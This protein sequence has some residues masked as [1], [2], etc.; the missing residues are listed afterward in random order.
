[1]THGNPDEV[2][3]IPLERGATMVLWC[4]LPAQRLPL[5]VGWYFMMLRNGVP[6]AYGGGGLFAERAEHGMNVLEAFR[7]SGD[8]AWIFAQISRAAHALCPTPW[9]VTRKFQVGGDGN[10]EGL[11]SGA[12]WFYD[13][14]GFRST[15]AGVRRLADWERRRIAR[16]T[17][18]RS[19]R[20]VLR[21]L[22]SAD[23][24]LSLEGQPPA[25]YREY[26]LDAVGLAVAR[27]TSLRFGG[28]RLR[29]EDWLGRRAVACW[30]A[31][32]RISAGPD[33]ASQARRQ[34]ETLL[35][36][37]VGDRKEPT[38]DCVRLARLKGGVLEA[39]Y[40]RAMAECRAWIRRLASDA[41][42]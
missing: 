33:S 16:G 31:D 4:M 24:V 39:E 18:Y 11:D 19:P 3:E 12:Y 23:V 10:E 41:G 38:P 22:A 15:D 6:V 9:I 30:G 2:Y 5:E 14:L 20:R 7:K 27:A 26:P 34:V 17:G 35:F 21:T 29:L 36:D 37:L 28:A 40:A 42:A 1:M 32:P 25:A 8:A 13:K